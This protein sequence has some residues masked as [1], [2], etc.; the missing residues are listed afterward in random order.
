MPRPIWSGAISFGLVNVPVKLYNTVK[1][2]TVSFHQLRKADGCRIRLKKVCSADGQEV[3][4]DNIVKGYEISPDRYVVISADE[5]ETLY[6][7][8]NRSIEIE[9]FVQ[10]S[11]IDP[12]Y[13]EQSYYLVP[14]KG[15][16]KA[17]TLLLTAMRL[18]GKVAIAKFVL[19]NKEY[20]AALR[21]AGQ[22]LSLSTMF[23]ADEIIPLEEL[24]GLPAAETEPTK[25]EL[26]MAQQLIES[27]AAE[28]EPQKYHNEYHQRVM[29]LIERKAEGQDIVA[30]PA[31]EEGAK[32]IDLMAALEASLAAVKKQPAVNQRRKKAS[33]H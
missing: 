5:L 33:G 18:S 14:D 23:F 4:G 11:E 13:Y 22:A 1:K 9:D 8:A 17:Y 26:A 19:R 20:L 31:A 16:A 12:I 24:E 29:D 27:L 21:P 10:L 32:V 15:A 25:K 3:P 6:P 7:K 2:K 30:K 28:F